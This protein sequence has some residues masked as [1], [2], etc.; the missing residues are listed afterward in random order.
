MGDILSNESTY[1][2]F[3]VHNNLH[4]RLLFDNIHLNLCYLQA[5]PFGSKVDSPST[6]DY[7]LNQ[8]TKFH[9]TCQGCISLNYCNMKFLLTFRQR[10]SILF[11]GHHSNSEVHHRL[12]TLLEAS[13][14]LEVRLERTLRFDQ[15][16]SAF[17]P[18][19][20]QGQ[21]RQQ[22]RRSDG[23]GRDPIQR[24]RDSLA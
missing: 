16:P 10:L 22:D 18:G 1:K 19:E 14:V 3:D 21:E 15:V 24:R 7:I 5:N 12:Y 4:C 2:Q 11:I 8:D 17:A 13:Q 20:G 6:S 9:E 23:R